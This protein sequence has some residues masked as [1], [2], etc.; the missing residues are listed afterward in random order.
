MKKETSVGFNF[1]RPNLDEKCL[2]QIKKFKESKFVSDTSKKFNINIAH[3]LDI[4]KLYVNGSNL[5][6]EEKNMS[7]TIKGKK[8]IQSDRNKEPEG[9]VEIIEEDYKKNKN[10]ETLSSLRESS[11]LKGF[12]ETKSRNAMKISHSMIPFSKMRNFENVL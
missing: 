5:L 1:V 11:Y 3:F 4:S 7:T 6:E 8:Y 9:E 12:F 10:K 2:P